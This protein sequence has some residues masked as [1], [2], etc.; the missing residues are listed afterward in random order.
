[1]Q[2]GFTRRIFLGGLAASAAARHSAPHP[3][4]ASPVAIGQCKTYGIEL[5]P[6]MEKMFDQLG[7][8]GK[9]VRNKTVA[10][11]INLTGSTNYRLGHAPAELTHYTH[12]AVIGAA[13]HLIGRAGARRIRL[14]ECSWSSAEPLEETMMQVA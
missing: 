1:M 4:P 14:L 5:A 9:L 10:I 11:K 8:L 7:G 13:V 12:P 2:H 3:A 6:A